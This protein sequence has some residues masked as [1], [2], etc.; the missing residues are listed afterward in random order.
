M[1]TAALHQDLLAG[2]IPDDELTPVSRDCRVGKAGN[3]A[4]GDPQRVLDLLGEKAEPRSQ[5]QPDPGPSAAEAAPKL[6]NCS[7]YIAQNRFLPR[8]RLAVI[9]P[10]PARGLPILSV[11]SPAL[12]AA[13]QR[14]LARGEETESTRRASQVTGAHGLRPTSATARQRSSQQRRAHPG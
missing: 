3:C 14:A 13:P 2:P 1:E 12:M 10:E 4:I 5:H 7:V 9:T 6:S 11:G 8:Y